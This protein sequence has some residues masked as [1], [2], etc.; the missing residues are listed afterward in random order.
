MQK[1]LS[2]LKIKI[3]NWL[4][5]FRSTFWA[6]LKFILI[7]NMSFCLFL[8]YPREVFFVCILGVFCPSKNNGPPQLYAGRC[9]KKKYFCLSSFIL[10]VWSCFRV[11]R[12]EVTNTTRDQYRKNL[13]QKNVLWFAIP[14]PITQIKPQSQFSINLKKFFVE[15]K[16]S[17]PPQYK[18][19]MLLWV[20]LFKR[21]GI[22]F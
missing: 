12:I 9:Q 7:T 19:T 4:F 13:M 16:V 17:P 2:G 14:T 1:L 11:Q 8:K 6:F 21:T 18:K 3:Q 15:S 20:A 22:C 5:L 10:F